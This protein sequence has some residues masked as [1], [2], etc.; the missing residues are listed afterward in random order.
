[1]GMGFRVVVGTSL[2]VLLLCGVSL[3]A[4]TASG[5]SSE[6][7]A[8]DVGSLEEELRVGV[9]ELAAVLAESRAL[10]AK[11]LGRLEGLAELSL[12]ELS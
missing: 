2:A 4:P 5:P 8:R 6:R 10:F 1:M 11:V 9:A 3:V 12:A 7:P